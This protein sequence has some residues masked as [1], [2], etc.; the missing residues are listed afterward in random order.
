MFLTK[1]TRKIMFIQRQNVEPKKIEKAQQNSPVRYQSCNLAQ[2]K[3]HFC[4]NFFKSLKDHPK[5]MLLRVKKM[6]FR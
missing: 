5:I 1:I 2:G 4:L 3:Y 6:R